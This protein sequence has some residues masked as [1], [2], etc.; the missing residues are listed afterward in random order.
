MRLQPHISEEARFND[1]SE[2][3][4]QDGTLSEDGFSELA[5]E[6]V[7]HIEDQRLLER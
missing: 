7:E 6:A 5:H 2:Y 3:R 1:T 4:D